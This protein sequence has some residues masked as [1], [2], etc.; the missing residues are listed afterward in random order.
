MQFIKGYPELIEKARAESL[1][2]CGMDGDGIQAPGAIVIRETGRDLH[3][4][5]VHFAN[6]QCG[7]YHG[8]EYCTTR[9]EADETALDKIRRYDP[10]KAL[11][12]SFHGGNLR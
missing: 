1:M 5:V 7:G 4:F 12:N 11:R 2:F 10:T 6:T 3:P 8:G 9:R